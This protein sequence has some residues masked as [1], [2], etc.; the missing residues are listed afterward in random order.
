MRA[1]LVAIILI[2]GTAGMAGCSRRGS[3]R[4]ESHPASPTERVDRSLSAAAQFLISR[5]A[6]D[7]AWRSEVYGAFKDGGSL[8]PLVLN[9]LL[10]LPRSENVDAA[11]RKG[12]GYLAAMVRPDGTIDPGPD[13][14]TYPVYTASL[15]VMALSQPRF[16]E[17]KKA[18][19][20]WLAYL[21]ARQLT[22]DLGWEPADK[23][24][25]GWGY[26]SV[27]P[28]KPKPG[29]SRPLLTESN[30]SATVFA[31]EALAAAGCDKN[32]P[33]FKKALMLVQRCQNFSDEARVA[34]PRFD[35]GGFFFIYEDPVRNKA[36]SAA[37]DAAGRERFISYGS[38]TADGLRGLLACGLPRDHLRVSAARHWLE[39]NF[40]VTSHPGNYPKD[41]EPSREAVYYYYCCSL[42]KALRG[43]GRDEIDTPAGKVFWSE[44]LA[45]ELMKRQRPDGS[46][47]NSAVAQREDDPAV[48]TS[49][50]VTALCQCRRA[51]VVREMEP[52]IEP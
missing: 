43:L 49:L 16:E 46:W 28:R 30:T 17:H 5:Q 14:L 39:R 52:V 27:L 6:A 37:K 25:G 34:E 45:D 18:R 15:T 41:R 2:A 44:A 38:T 40:T 21:R 12:A 20:A 31:L 19:D 26:C 33:A 23:E 3:E 24:Y 47:A 35:D 51:I 29:E 13:G 48:A 7:G 1:T 11:C 22:E 42:A 9:A 36:G 8:T 32:D 50:A 4:S 10:Y